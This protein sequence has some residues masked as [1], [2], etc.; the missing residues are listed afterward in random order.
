ME[1]EKIICIVGPTASGKSGLAMQLAKKLGGEIICADSQTIRRGLN[2]GTAKP[3]KQDQA[4]VPHHLLDIIDP[5]QPYSAAQFK[6][7]AEAATQAI[8]KRGKVPII[9]GGTGLYIDALFYNYTFL[10]SPK[11]DALRNSLAKLTVEELQQQIVHKKLPMPTNSKNP[12]HLIRTLE[13]G[14]MLANNKTPRSDMLLFGLLLEP[15]ILQ[16]RIQQRIETIFAEGFL[17]E[18]QELVQVYGAPPASPQAF[19][20]I[21][22]KLALAYLQQGAPEDQL[23]QLKNSIYMAEKN[24]AKRQLTWFKR[25]VHTTWYESP[26][27]AYID[28]CSKIL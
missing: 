26:E 5:Y 18:V 11:N 16:Q 17:Q 27:Q 4:A 2:L 28:I 23:Q 10:P 20:A 9:V 12:R 13:S 8:Q 1:S 19:D 15:A 14:G 22:Y 6:N 7:D 24:Y 21:A 3:T 25:N